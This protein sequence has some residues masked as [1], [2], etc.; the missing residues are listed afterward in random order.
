M[1]RLCRRFYIDRA[2]RSY[3]C[4]FV[5]LILKKCW[6]FRHQPCLRADLLGPSSRLSWFWSLVVRRSFVT[7]WERVMEWKHQFEIKET[8]LD[9]EPAMFGLKCRLDYESTLETW[10]FLLWRMEHE[11]LLEWNSFDL[12]GREFDIRGVFGCK[13]S[14]LLVH[15]VYIENIDIRWS[16]CW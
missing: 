13:N 2:Q 3:R 12:W 9:E 10:S 15:I 5:F 7:S 16:L 6:L 8:F 1:R 11:F 4:L 14:Y